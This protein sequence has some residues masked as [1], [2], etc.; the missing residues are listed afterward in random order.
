MQ[1]LKYLVKSA[2]NRAGISRQI[3]AA[4]IVAA[5][6]VFLDTAV[7]PGLRSSVRI[8]SFQHGV[9]KVNCANAVAAHELRSLESGVR[10][11]IAET[12]PKAELRTLTIH[13]GTPPN[14]PYD[15]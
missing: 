13:I 4:Q 6:K 15:L 7:L 1:S 5:V 10:Q 12:D 8:I 14:T 2:V 3:S 11:I 9:L